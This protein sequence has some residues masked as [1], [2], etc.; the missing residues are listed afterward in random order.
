VG[1]WFGQRTT[2][3]KRGWLRLKDP[4]PLEHKTLGHMFQLPMSTLK[5]GCRSVMLGAITAV[6]LAEYSEVRDWIVILTE[7]PS[8]TNRRFQL[9]MLKILFSLLE[10]GLRT[11][12]LLDAVGSPNR[13]ELD[14]E[15]KLRNGFL[16]K[17]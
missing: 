7:W 15:R 6:M 3:R 11:A 5:L 1:A 16:Q 14:R 2:S 9:Q 13:V 8:V 10:A 12:T 17:R 4:P